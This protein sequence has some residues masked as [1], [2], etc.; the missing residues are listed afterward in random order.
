ME[1]D[2]MSPRHV[3][4]HLRVDWSAADSRS[5]RKNQ[6]RPARVYNQGLEALPWQGMVDRNIGGTHMR[7]SRSLLLA[8]LVALTAGPAFAQ[9]RIAP[10]APIAK[11]QEMK[12][13][14]GFKPFKPYEPPPPAFKPVT[15]V[16]PYTTPSGLYPEL[17][18][19]PKKPRSF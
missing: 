1:A 3:A 13:D 4:K 8:G 11:P 2:G 18:P 14:P 7:L 16:D 6:L 5:G 12:P 19:K 9:A 10:I 17:Y 15:H